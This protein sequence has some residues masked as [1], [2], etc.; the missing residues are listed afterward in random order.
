MLTTPL[1][2]P[3]S[4][5]ISFTRLPLN[6]PDNN[7]NEYTEIKLFETDEEG[8]KDSDSLLKMGNDRRGVCGLGPCAVSCLVGNIFFPSQIYFLFKS[9]SLGNQN[10]LR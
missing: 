1:P 10:A 6:N 4:H 7:N 8:E 3:S 5:P 2:T 9:P